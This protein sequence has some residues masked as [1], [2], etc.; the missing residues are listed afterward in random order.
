[1]KVATIV[2]N[3]EAVDVPISKSMAETILDI[4]EDTTLSCSTL[5]QV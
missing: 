1:V 5:S 4:D 3:I 2:E